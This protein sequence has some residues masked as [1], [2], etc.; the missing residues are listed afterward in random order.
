MELHGSRRNRFSPD[1][2]GRMLKELLQAR[3]AHSSIKLQLR[4]SAV[5][6]RVRFSPSIHD[7]LFNY[8][9][10]VVLTNSAV[11]ND[12]YPLDGKSGDSREY[13]AAMLITSL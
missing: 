4:S 13:R 6:H 11:T 3:Y 1:H 8:V 7:Q 2:L 12:L 5:T 10:L 9:L